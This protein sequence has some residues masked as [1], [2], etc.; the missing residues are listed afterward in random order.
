MQNAIELERN[1]NEDA[2][3]FIDFC[4]ATIGLEKAARGPWHVAVG[5][6]NERVE[7]LEVYMIVH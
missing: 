5:V 7:W 6:A 2:S 3:A 4:G 1:H